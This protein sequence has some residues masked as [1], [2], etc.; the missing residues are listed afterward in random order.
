MGRLPNE[1]AAEPSTEE[2]RPGAGGRSE[3]KSANF[4]KIAGGEGG[5]RERRRRERR[6]RRRRERRDV[7]PVDCNST[8][9]G[10]G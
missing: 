9:R 6:E 5:R 2:A 10:G 1:M 4:S 3:N 8:G 7:E